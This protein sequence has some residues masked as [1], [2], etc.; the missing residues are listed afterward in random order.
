MR[1]WPVEVAGDSMLPTFRA[2]DWLLARRTDSARVGDVVI[3]ARPDRPELLVI[4]R[5]RRR[6]SDGWWVEG[7]NPGSSD[8]S[9]L[10]GPVQQI[11]G[12]VVLRYRPGLMFI[13]R[14]RPRGP[15]DH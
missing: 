1:W 7:D 10:F 8:D 12:R 4:K 2:G 13:R 9:R 15:A 5:V 3:L 14:Q 6:D 11:H